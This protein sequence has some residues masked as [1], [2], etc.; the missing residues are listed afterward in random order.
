MSRC[1]TPVL[2][3][4]VLATVLVPFAAA[5]TQIVAPFTLS[6]AAVDAVV[7]PGETAIFNV[8][9]GNPE[10]V[11][12]RAAT[13]SAA[14][15]ASNWTFNF[16][17][18]TVVVPHAS[19][20]WTLWRIFVPSG[21][22][23]GT[24]PA[25]VEAA[26]NG[27]GGVTRANVNVTV[28]E[29]PVSPPPA[30]PAAPDIIFS[31][32]SG[33]AAQSGDTAAGTLTLTSRDPR[34][35]T[36]TI[37]I[38]PNGGWAPAIPDTDQTRILAPGTTTTARLLVP[39]PDLE[40]NA[41][42]DFAVTIRATSSDGA[43]KTF[44]TIWSVTGVAKPAA[45]T[46]TTQTSSTGGSPSSG[47]AT[48]PRAS[49]T[50]N[51]P[52]L[53]V[54]IDPIEL[55]IASGSAKTAVVQ[56]RNTGSVPLTITLSGTPPPFWSPFAFA[57]DNVVELGAGDTALVPMTVS[58]P[59]GIPPGG[60]AESKVTAVGDNGLVRTATFV[61]RVTPAAPRDTTETA[62]LEAPATP[63]GGLPVQ[64]PSV[65]IVAGLAAVG[66]AAIVVSS[67]P[68]REKLLWGAA[69]LYTRLARPD[70][71]G[72]EDREKL[73]RLVETQPGIHFHALQ[74]DLGWNTGTLTY[75][76]R[77]LERH[78]FMVS[79]RDGLYRRFYL[80]GAAPR[81]EVFEN[82]GPTG[83]RADVIEA[84]RNT[85]GISQS[86]LALG[87]GANKQTVNYHVKALERAGTIRVEKRGRDTYLFPGTGVPVG[88][89]EAVRA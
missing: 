29:R 41:T 46:D 53:D 75:H 34:T 56:L 28:Q 73:Y 32:T 81:K 2:V 45:D 69:G 67:R 48:V 50:L 86:D 22:A 54:T 58:A 87:L 61:I 21:A 36:L 25:M 39:I 63:D 33:D 27:F 11:F 49:G 26:D 55:S 65:L 60:L 16:T 38:A 74:R 71:L 89:D 77:V 64:G 10:P 31:T 6:L 4:T 66:S 37:S 88:S 44:A 14:V 15:P 23:P 43:V 47:T 19:S 79:R 18:D 78:G 72:H 82:Q 24:Y 70:V 7:Y 12:D 5:Q 51:L 52:N 8:T 20:N 84:V 35:L 62:T 42:N 68:L 3:A 30:P 1:L 17:S 76:L 57:P 85:P 83:L 13:M 40:Q 9:I 80:S 59:D